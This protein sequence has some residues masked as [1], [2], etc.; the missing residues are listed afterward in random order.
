M[1]WVDRRRFTLTDTEELGIETTDVLDEPAPARYRPAGHTR[2]RVVVL[3]DVPSV[4]GDLGDQVV[5]AQQ[6]LP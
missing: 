5:A 6:R 2:L 1:L 4:G 3:V